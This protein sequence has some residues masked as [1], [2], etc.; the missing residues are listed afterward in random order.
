MEEAYE[1]LA[2]VV[3]VIDDYRFVINRGAHHEIKIG[4][5]FLVF[6]LGESIVDPDTNEDLGKLEIVRGRARVIHIQERMATLESRESHSVP[7]RK[8]IIRREGGI[9]ISA[10]LSAPRVEEIEEGGE[11]IRQE[12]DAELGDLV[13]PI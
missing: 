10:L 8:K 1:E 12:I 7:G 11:T 2:K 3:K 4:G 9:G 13:R 5:N 6:H